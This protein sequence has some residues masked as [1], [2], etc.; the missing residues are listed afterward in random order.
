MVI[1]AIVALA[2]LTSLSPAQTPAPPTAPAPS[3][4]TPAQMETLKKLLASSDTDSK[5]RIQPTA[6][7][8][9]EIAKA[10]D[11]NVLAEKPDPELDKKL[12]ADMTNAV[13]E[14]VKIAMDIRLNAIADIAK[15][16]TPDQKKFLLA[17][18]DKPE[19]N[20]DLAELVQRRLMTTVP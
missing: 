11:R 17:E 12:R 18:L 8:I 6:E 19:T 13:L 9:T 16:L 20:P 7:K 4:L 15:V 1:S 14:T 2:L 5:A 3:S 10:I